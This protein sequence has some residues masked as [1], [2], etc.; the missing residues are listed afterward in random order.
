[1][2]SDSIF[3]INII[4]K[5]LVAAS[6]PEKDEFTSHFALNVYFTVFIPT[7]V[8]VKLY[9]DALQPL[10]DKVKFMDTYTCVHVSLC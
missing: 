4:N 6:I 9:K 5:N 10:G 2:A 7:Y 1:M 8:Q 3:I